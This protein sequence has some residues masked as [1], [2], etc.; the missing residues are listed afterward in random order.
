MLFVDCVELMPCLFSRIMQM[1]VSLEKVGRSTALF[2]ACTA[3]GGTFG[4]AAYAMWKEQ[5]DPPQSKRYWNYCGVT[6]F[7]GLSIFATGTI[8]WL[9]SALP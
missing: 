2:G 4:V 6:M 8:I 1:S 3:I 7:G 5:N 9:V